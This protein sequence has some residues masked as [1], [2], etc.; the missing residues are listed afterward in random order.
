MHGYKSGSRGWPMLARAV[1]TLLIGREKKGGLVRA[2]L[3][4]ESGGGGWQMLANSHCKAHTQYR[5][6]NALCKTHTQYIH[7]VHTSAHTHRRMKT[8]RLSMIV[9]WK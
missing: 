5:K 8:G 9:C 1:S 2:W 7:T 4:F 6:T 3:Q